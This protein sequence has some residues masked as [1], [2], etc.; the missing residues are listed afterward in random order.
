[1]QR[2]FQR[3]I[4]LVVVAIIGGVVAMAILGPAPAAP[5]KTPTDTFTRVDVAVSDR[6][7]TV[8]PSTVPAGLVEVSVTD[9]RSPANQR[10]GLIVTS[11]LGLLTFGDQVNAYRMFGSYTLRSGAATGVLTVVPPQLSA[12]RD[13]RT[14]HVVMRPTDFMA[15]GR[16]VRREEPTT[17][18]ASD[19][20]Q[21]RDWTS[22]H[23][24]A[25]TFILDNHSH[26][27]QTCSIPSLMPARTIGSGGRVK[28]S[29]TFAA[30]PY[31]V[32]CTTGTFGLWVN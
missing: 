3:S 17:S 27:S 30:Q 14:L 18:L 26:T 15:P 12:P 6:A 10:T 22:V 29:L 4:S 16:E 31:E 24:G 23:A 20:P 28:L 5:A 19:I 21:D 11:P 1:V 9:H 8:K 25:K 13:E 7:I 2:H 32:R